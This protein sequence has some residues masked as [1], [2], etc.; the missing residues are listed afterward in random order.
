MLFVAIGLGGVE[1]AQSLSFVVTG[2]VPQVIVNVAHPTALIFALDL[3]LVVPFFVLGAIWLWQ[4]QP[5][6]YVLGAVLNVK[7]A[8]Y[9]L[10]LTAASVPAA[11]AGFPEAAAQVPIWGFLLVGSLTAC[12]LLLGNVQSAQSGERG[13][14]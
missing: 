12:G 5:W 8:V 10:A 14:I 1:I 4:R 11:R 9:M 7:G 3:S 13:E 2:Q 6:G